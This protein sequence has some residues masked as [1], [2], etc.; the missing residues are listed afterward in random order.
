M[1]R[2]L[3]AGVIATGTALVSTLVAGVGGAPAQAAV[4]ASGAACNTTTTFDITAGTLQITVPDTVA[5]ANDAAP[6]GYAWGQ[7]GAITVTDARASA[8][9]SWTATVTS[10][11]FITAGG[12]DPGETVDAT[13]VYYCSGPASTTTGDGTFTPGQ[14]GCA[15]PP[16]ITGES[17]GAA[18]TAF[19]HT[20]GTGNN[21]A[22]WN[23][24]IGIDTALA[25]VGG[26]YT[27]TIAHVV[28]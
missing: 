11:D 28:A 14:T 26:T 3:R 6:D 25:N 4:C 19:S 13:N 20:G 7:L 16:P 5:L 1:S 18:K 10:G 22:S 12:N 15:A 17:L 21:S 27:G 9:P 8:T 2:Y 24:L 23:P